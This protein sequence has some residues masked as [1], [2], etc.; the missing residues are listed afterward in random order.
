MLLWARR[1]QGQP[2]W[3]Q[4]I[5]DKLGITKQSVYWHLRRLE[6]DGELNGAVKKYRTR[7]E[8]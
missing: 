8:G 6:A 4:R 7:S 5:A 1:W 3:V 2:F